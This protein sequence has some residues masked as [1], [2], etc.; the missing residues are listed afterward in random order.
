MIILLW[1]LFFPFRN[2]K[3]GIQDQTMAR[4]MFQLR[5]VQDG[6]RYQKLHTQGTGCLLRHLL[7]GKVFDAL[8]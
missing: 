2:E 6:Y 4:E 7:R 5:S 8:R 1:L 3:N